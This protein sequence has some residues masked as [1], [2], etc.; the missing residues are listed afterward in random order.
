MSTTTSD[1]RSR[2]WAGPRG[3]EARDYEST[4]TLLRRLVGDAATLFAQ[5][6]ALLKAETSESIRELKAATMSIAIGGAV[7][8]AGII[9]LLLAAVYGLSN[10]MDP[11]LAALIVGGVVT[12]IGIVMLATGRGKLEPAAIAPRRTAASLRKDTEM[13]KGVSQH[14]HN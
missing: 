13:I 6:L 14:E 9:F 11:W 5:E 7:L 2:E 3:V 1:V 12:L 10:V 4:P 8:F